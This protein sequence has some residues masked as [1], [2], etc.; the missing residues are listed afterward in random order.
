MAKPISAASDNVPKDILPG[1]PGYLASYGSLVSFHVGGE[2]KE[3]AD[4]LVGSDPEVRLPLSLLILS[5]VPKAIC[6]IKY[7]Q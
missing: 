2:I 5:C 6:S 7:V 3:P 4:G 1:L